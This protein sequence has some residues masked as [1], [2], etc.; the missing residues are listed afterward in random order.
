MIRF[1]ARALLALGLCATLVTPISAQQ[2]AP[3]QPAASAPAVEVDRSA[4]LYEG[5]DIPRDAGWQFGALRNGLRFAVRRNGV[6][7]GQVTIRLRVDV[8]SLMEQPNEA[9]WAHL[10]EHLAF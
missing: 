3:R 10:I 5:S 8:G 2:V 7:P 6:P 4:W 9:G 1:P